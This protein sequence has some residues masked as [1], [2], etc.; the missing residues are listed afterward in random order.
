[1]NADE[2]VERALSVAGMRC[3]YELG[4]GGFDPEGEFPWDSAR[5]CDCSGFTAWVLGFSRKTDEPFYVRYNGGW[6]NTDAMW[7]DA[8]EPVGMFRDL[9]HPRPGALVV[10]PDARSTSGHVGV[11]SEVDSDGNVTGI[12]HCSSENYLRTRDAIRENAGRRLMINPRRRFI[13]YEMIET[14]AEEPTIGLR[15]F[16]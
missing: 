14:A 5:R 2:V 8:G 10:Y 9:S 11:I 4:K 3:R 7:A 16:G 12:V 1:M 15:K 6:V 13:W